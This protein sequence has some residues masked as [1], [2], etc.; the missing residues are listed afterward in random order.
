MIQQ[1][2]PLPRSR[3][4]LERLA[5][6]VAGLERKLKDTGDSHA[7]VAAELAAAKT[8]KAALQDMVDSVSARLDGAIERVENLLEG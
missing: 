1:S 4:A 3:A 7:R 5:E 6:A 2:N 8:E